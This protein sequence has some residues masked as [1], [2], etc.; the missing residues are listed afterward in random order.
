MSRRTRFDWRPLRPLFRRRATKV[1]STAFPFSRRCGSS[2]SKTGSFLTITVNTLV[3][4]VANDGVTS[5]RE[6]MTA[7]V[8]SETIN[9]SVTGTISLTSLGQLT[10]NKNLTI[11]GPGANLL[12]I[13]AYDPDANGANDGDGSRVF[14]IDDSNA[15]NVLSVS[16]SGLTF[17]NGDSITSGGAIRSTENLTVSDSTISGNWSSGRGGGIYSTGA[18]SQLTLLRTIV[19]GNAAMSNGGG[20]AMFFG[21]TSIDQSTIGSNIGNFSGGGVFQ[22][23]GQLNLTRSTVSGNSTSNRGGGVFTSFGTHTISESLIVNNS[24]TVSGI[25]RGG[26]GI[27]KYG[28]SL[29]VT[30][31]TISGNQSWQNG[32]GISNYGG[33][34]DV[35]HSTITLNWADVDTAGGGLGGGIFVT[36]GT[37]T[38]DHTI[39]SGNLRGF[40]TRDD[41]SGPSRSVSV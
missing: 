11:Q 35:R 24:S 31:S 3:D 38:F 2:C 13:K 1:R 4:V 34:L 7:A 28:G 18:N 9:F 36:S 39:I 10:I 23:S 37:T 15:A 21:G 30:N 6:A 20:V 32:G 29:T 16:I 14:D 27:G 22:Y 26:G 41:A 17:T 12:T 33:T 5:L 8:P 19:S 40:G 25:S